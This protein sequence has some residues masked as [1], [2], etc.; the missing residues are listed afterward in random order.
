MIGRIAG[1]FAILAGALVAVGAFPTWV[2]LNTGGGSASYNAFNIMGD[3]RDAIVT[4]VLAAVLLVVGFA[5]TARPFF[6]AR[7]LGALAGV[8][9][10]I[11]AGLLFFSLAPQAHAL[12]A[13]TG[14]ATATS[15]ELGLW[16]IAGGGLLGLLAAMTA[17][18][19]RPRR[20]VAARAPA[21]AAPPVDRERERAAAPAAAPARPEAAP[22]E[23]PPAA[24]PAAAGRR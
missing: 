23:R 21:A 22:A 16:I 19:A 1:F 17:T 20:V 5:L 6:L 14:Q 11:W 18:T 2:T 12:I 24:P 10:A 13:P 3:Y 8:A 7:G 9:A 4:F 15:I